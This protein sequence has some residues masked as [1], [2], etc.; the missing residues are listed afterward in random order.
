MKSKILFFGDSIVK[1]KN[2]SKTNSWA[3]QLIKLINSNSK[4]KFAFGTYSY[5]GL[6]S[7]KALELLPQILIKNKNLAPI[8]YS[9][10]YSKNFIEIQDFG[11]QTIFNNLNKK[12]NDKLKYF[13]KIIDLLIK[14]QAIKNKKIKNQ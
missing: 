6:N 10:N 7:R 3:S 13:K 12:R 4:E 9:E 11:N 14:I 1:Y 5:V 8:L 2:N